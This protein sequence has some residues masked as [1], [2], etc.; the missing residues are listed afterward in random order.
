L[1]YEDAADG[2]LSKAEIGQMQRDGV[3][4]V[5]NEG[6]LT[7]N[8]RAFFNDLK[9]TDATAFKDRAADA[10]IRSGESSDGTLNFD[11]FKSAYEKAGGTIT[12]EDH[13]GRPFCARG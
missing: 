11:E 7:L 4:S 10:L 8:S 2:S 3:L 13:R 5:S 1:A 9:Y 12:D 6:D